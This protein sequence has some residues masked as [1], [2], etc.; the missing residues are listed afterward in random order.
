[1]LYTYLVNPQD[2]KVTTCPVESVL[3]LLYTAKE[4]HR[5]FSGETANSF[6]LELQP[7]PDPDP[8]QE[9]LTRV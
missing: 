2:V 3:T 6:G 9:S 1:M 4:R 7:E 8:K 5:D